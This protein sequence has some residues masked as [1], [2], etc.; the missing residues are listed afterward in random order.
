MEG[1]KG[2]LRQCVVTS[3]VLVFKIKYLDPKDTLR[4]KLLESWTFQLSCGDFNI[5]CIMLLVSKSL[6]LS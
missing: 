2:Y 6:T 1:M 4:R 5:F 3:D